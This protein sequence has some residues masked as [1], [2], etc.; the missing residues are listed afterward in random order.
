MLREDIGI[1]N[2]ILRKRFL[3]ELAHLK[4]ITDYS[5]CDGAALYQI[6][7]SMNVSQYTYTLLQ[8]GIDSEMLAKLTEDQLRL[9]CKIE[10]SI[11]RRKIADTA[12]SKCNPETAQILI[13]N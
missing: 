1:K 8:C 7:N 12:K 11:H 13:H 5:S 2:S 4:R 6:L 3:R 10:N 9:E